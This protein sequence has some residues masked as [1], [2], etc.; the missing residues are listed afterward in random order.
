MRF[1][2][3]KVNSLDFIDNIIEDKK[4]KERNF[5]DI[6]TGTTAVAKHYKRKGYNLI[7]NDNLEF[8]YAFQ[9]AY[10]KNNSYPQFEKLM[11]LI[12]PQRLKK[13]AIPHEQKPLYA[14]IEYLNNLAPQTD[15]VYYNYSEGGTK[16]SKFIRKYFTDDNAK[17]IDAIREKIQEWHNDNLIYENEYN[18]L[19][20]SLIEAVPFVANIAGTYG[21]FLKFWERRTKNSLTLEVPEVIVSEGNHEI[22]KQDANIFA[23]GLNCE[24][25]YM[26]PPFNE[27]QYITNYHLLETIA[28]W[29]KPEVYGK[30]GLRPYKD[31]RSAY[32]S[33]KMSYVA[34]R[35][36]VNKVDCKHMLFHYNTEGIM[37]LNIVSEILKERGMSRSF[38]VYKRQFRRFKSDKNRKKGIAGEKTNREYADVDLHEVVFY[39]EAKPKLK[40]YIPGGY[41]KYRKVS[42][43][44]I[45]IP[46][47]GLYDIRNKLNELTGPEWVYGIN[48]IE[49]TDYADD[50]LKFSKYIEITRYPTKGRGAYSHDLRKIHP[51]PKPPQLMKKIIEF[52]TRRDAWVLDPFMG[53]GGTLLGCSLC[54]RNG[55]GIDLNREYIEIYKKVCLKEK[56]KEQI[57]RVG[58]SY[59]LHKFKDVR[60]HKFD[61]ILTDPPYANMMAKVK[62][63]E[64]AKKENNAATPFTN[65]EEDLGN[66]PVS[67]FLIRLREIIEKALNYL[68]QDKYIVIFTKDFQPTKEHHNM[69]HVDIIE[70]LSKVKLLTF[71]GYKIWYD[72]TMNLYPYGYPFG[73]VSNQLHQFILIFKKERV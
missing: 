46:K 39:I 23:E 45:S 42:K 70:E 56:L 63:G 16:N 72:K 3:S 57:T 6:F 40:F 7:T 62:T 14:I 44:G 53:V 13:E 35:D 71:K 67:V 73:Y 51:S 20:T 25:L 48:S 68:K 50:I 18:I 38:K 26:D 2:G 17:K 1:I 12:K 5:C 22:N 47:R 49:E 28:L 4:I 59:D 66:L 30:S 8:S 69:L 15:F 32:C 33:K 24:V 43:Y 11:H 9:Y 21:A 60:N 52:F 37:K 29:D 34:L 10:I 58:D 36:L 64:K 31:E 41:K 61:L 65:M 27:R 55:V 19:I 54:G